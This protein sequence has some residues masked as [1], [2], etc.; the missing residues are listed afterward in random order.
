MINHF[1][2]L[3]MYCIIRL[4]KFANSENASIQYFLI[5]NFSLKEGE[6]VAF[7]I[8]LLFS[9]YFSIKIC[10]KHSCKNARLLR[11]LMNHKNEIIIKLIILNAVYLNGTNWEFNWNNF[12]RNVR[13]MY[14]LK[15]YI[16]SHFFELYLFLKTYINLFNFWICIFFFVCIIQKLTKLIQYILKFNWLRRIY[17]KNVLSNITVCTV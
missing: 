14:I 11:K 4:L 16:F 12:K 9:F 10:W 7:Y 8:F 5:E 15:H 6:S 3:N 1:N 2:K 13:N 17:L